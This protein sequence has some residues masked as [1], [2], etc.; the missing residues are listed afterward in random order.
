MTLVEVYPLTGRTHQ[1]RTHFKS[2]R[3]PLVGDTLYGP[4][5]KKEGE[6]FNIDRTMLHASKVTFFLHETGDKTVEA[7]LP[8]DFET[9]LA[10]LR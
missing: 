4:T 2:I 3:H 10:K 5:R 1:I 6:V 9:V 8:T 7:P